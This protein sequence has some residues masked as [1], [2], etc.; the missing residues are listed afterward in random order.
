MF[1]DKMTKIYEPAPCIA[2]LI[3]SNIKNKKILYSSSGNIDAIKD[4]CIRY[5]IDY[6]NCRD[7]IVDGV[8]YLELGK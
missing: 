6:S 2:Y 8:K 7:H 1:F 5:K 4:Y 3:F